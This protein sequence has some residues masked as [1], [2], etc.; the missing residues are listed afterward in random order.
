MPYL[1]FLCTVRVHHFQEPWCV[2]SGSS[3][4][5]FAHIYSRLKGVVALASLVLNP[6]FSMECTRKEGAMLLQLRPFAAFQT[7]VFLIE[8]V[9]ELT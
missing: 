1:L 8:R 7:V 9:S 6:P 5:G 4:T 2:W 3:S